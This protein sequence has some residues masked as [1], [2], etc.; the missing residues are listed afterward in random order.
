VMAHIIC[1]K[2]GFAKALGFYLF[3]I[4]P[5]NNFRYMHRK[6]VPQFSLISKSGTRLLAGDRSWRIA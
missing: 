2:A 6:F 5:Q 1:F 4:W 3:R